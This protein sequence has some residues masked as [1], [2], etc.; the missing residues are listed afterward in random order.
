MAQSTMSLRLRHALRTGSAPFFLSLL[1]GSGCSEEVGGDGWV[2]PKPTDMGGSGGSINSGGD[3]GD[4]GPMTGGKGGS[5]GKTGSSGGGKGGRGGTGGGGRAGSGMTDGGAGGDTSSGPVCGN[6]TQEEGEECDDGNRKSGDGCTSDCRS[7]CEPCEKTHCR[8][9]FLQHAPTVANFYDDC[10][11]M[12]GNATEGKAAGTPRKELCRAVVDCARNQDCAQFVPD[13]AVEGRAIQYQFV[14]CFCDRDITE[15]GYINKCKVAPTS[16]EPKVEDNTF[17]PGDCEREFMEASE[18]DTLGEAFNGL[19]TAKLKPLGAANL[20]LLECDRKLCLEECFPE[21]SAGVVAQITADISAT[22]G[23]AGESALG[24]IIADAYRAALE[25]DFAFLNAAAIEPQYYAHPAGGW[26]FEATEGRSA[27]ADG[28]VLESEVMS[29]LFGVEVRN[30]ATNLSGGRELVSLELTGHEVYAFLDAALGTIDV[31]GLVYTWDSSLPNG[32]RVTSVN[33]G[34]S[35]LDKA[36]TYSVATNDELLTQV[37][38]A[39]NVVKSGKNP[40]N[41]LLRHLK[42]QNQPISPPSPRAARLN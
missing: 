17:V 5:G 24:A 21:E 3:G 22:R 15:G 14:R 4:D 40:A 13:D 20:L 32:A 7:G 2:P 1:V 11:N 18:R 25:T 38:A 6:G 23:D 27:D 10:F 37:V 28:R 39:K 26:L 35:P 19:A 42:A 33:I 34:P 16:P 9:V 36:A 12:P 41:E 31:S 29:S 8:E 30:N